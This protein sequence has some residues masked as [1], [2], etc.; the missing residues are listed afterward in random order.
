[1]DLANALLLVRSHR[2]GVE[3]RY[4]LIGV[5]ADHTA[6]DQISPGNSKTGSLARVT[7]TLLW[8]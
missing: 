4:L 1:M 7:L 2:R 5:E 6:T 3:T 8:S